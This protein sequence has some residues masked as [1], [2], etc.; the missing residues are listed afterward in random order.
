ME[1]DYWYKEFEKYRKEVWPEVTEIDE[2]VRKKLDDDYGEMTRQVDEIEALFHRFTF[3]LADAD[4][5]LSKIKEEKLP[6]IRPAL[7]TVGLKANEYNK[8]IFL[9]SAVSEIQKFRD[10]IKGTVDSIAKRVSLG[11]SKMK[12]E[13]EYR[14]IST[15]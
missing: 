3:I 9:E 5:F 4:E 8:K 13:K 10:K 7:E 6:H 1:K 11:Q 14:N 2:I 15:K 12:S